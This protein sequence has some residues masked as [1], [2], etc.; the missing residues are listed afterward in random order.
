MFV[1]RTHRAHHQAGMASWVC[2][3]ARD[4]GK[5][6]RV[7]T[8]LRAYLEQDRDEWLERRRMGLGASDAAAALGLS[9]WKSPL[10]LYIEKVASNTLIVESERIFWGKTLEPIVAQVYGEQNSRVL[11]DLGGFTCIEAQDLPIAYCT[12]DRV[13]VTN[14]SAKVVDEGLEQGA[15]VLFDGNPEVVEIKCVDPRSMREWS[16]TELPDHYALQGHHQMLV[17][18]LERVTF[19]VLVGGNQ[20][21]TWVI[22]RDETLL[23]D[24]AQAEESFWELVLKRTPP[25]VDGSDATSNAIR[26]HFASAS[27][28]HTVEVDKGLI[29]EL[30]DA[31]RRAKLAQEEADRL[32]N[33]VKLAMEDAE[34][35]LSEGEVVATWKASVSHRL[36]I[37]AIK[38]ELPEVATK[39]TTEARS[40]RFLMKGAK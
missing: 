36:N 10:A 2:A 8:A 26:H 20:L 33:M 9:P 5:D 40:R 25:L 24:L 6:L 22:D 23:A 29:R 37:D 13:D 32:E 12:L 14:G 18:G 19:A 35:A 1:A 39:Y 21:R 27:P 15:S 34:V 17:T 7:T 28:G 38:K 16:D 3:Y 31:R 30:I 4:D 11:V